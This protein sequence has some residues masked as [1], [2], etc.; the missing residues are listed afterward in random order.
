MQPPNPKRKKVRSRKKKKSNNPTQKSKKAKADKKR[1]RN[2]FQKGPTPQKKTTARPAEPKSSSV[3]SID[4]QKAV[5]KLKLETSF[6]T[7]GTI[8]S[9]A[10]AKDNVLYVTTS[11]YLSC[12]QTSPVKKDFQKDLFVKADDMVLTTSKSD[13]VELVVLLNSTQRTLSFYSL[14]RIFCICKFFGER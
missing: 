1:C 5:K 13:K 3:Q 8:E 10:A 4:S 11:D 2:C 7:K 6:R 9:I 14:E 12:Y